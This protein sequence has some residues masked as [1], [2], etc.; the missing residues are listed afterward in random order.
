MVKVVGVDAARAISPEDSQA[1]G[2]AAYSA[3]LTEVSEDSRHQIQNNWAD[4]RQW[5]IKQTT[6][7]V[8]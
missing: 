5:V 2:F 4:V 1:Q 6:A 8:S 7:E 3:W